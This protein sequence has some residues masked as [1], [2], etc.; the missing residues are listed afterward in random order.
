MDRKKDP[1]SRI[2]Q[3]KNNKNNK[4][5]NKENV[6]RTQYPDSP[7][8]EGGTDLYH[9]HLISKINIIPATTKIPPG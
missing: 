5:N 1:L 8:G 7:T 9:P 6:L 2:N 3:M 4:R